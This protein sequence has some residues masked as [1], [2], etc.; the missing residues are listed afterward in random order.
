MSFLAKAEDPLTAK[1]EAILTA[2]SRL[3]SL[4]GYA[5]V[6]MRVLANEVGTTP[7]ALY[8][9]YPDKEALYYAV[10]QYVFTDKAAAIGDLLAGNDAPDIR[11]ERLLLWFAELFSGDEIF[12]KLLHRE[13]I[14]GDKERIKFLTEEV[15]EAPFREIEKLMLQ[16]APELDARLSAISVIALIL[17]HF[18]LM[19]IMNNLTGSKK[20]DDDL[21]AFALHVKSLV[22]CG[23]SGKLG[24]KGGI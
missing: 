2:A 10:L 19:P 16:L 12:S 5:A 7:A 13:L 22:L 1:K 24:E 21:P 18:E 6:S 3:F 8:H 20:G 4:Q 23:L 9:H 17:G 11:L 14:D 15:I